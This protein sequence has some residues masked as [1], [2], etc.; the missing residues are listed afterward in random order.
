M[1]YILSKS[2][3]K[4]FTKLPPRTKEKVIIALECFT[5]NPEHHTLR[6]HQ[7]KGKWRGYF[8]IDI[9]SDIR[10]LYHREE[11]EVVRF[12]TI[13]SHSKLYQ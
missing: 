13:G 8:S 7:L 5:N 10:A 6:V 12:V 4:D 11:A 9:D 1:R 2:F 3:E